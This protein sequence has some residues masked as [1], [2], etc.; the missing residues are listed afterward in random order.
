LLRIKTGR[1]HFTDLKMA[2]RRRVR[3]YTVDSIEKRDNF[4]KINVQIVY[5]LNKHIDTP[6][7]M[8]S[9]CKRATDRAYHIMTC[10]DCRN[11]TTNQH[12]YIL[13]D[14]LF[15]RSFYD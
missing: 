10:I 4:Q 1:R 6:G 7:R 3:Q 2:A 13:Y 9:M 14:C 15:R 5:Y 12:I 11:I 8:I